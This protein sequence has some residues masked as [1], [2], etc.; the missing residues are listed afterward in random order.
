MAV[1]TEAKPE[2]KNYSKKIST[3]TIGLQTR[4]LE[5]IAQKAKGKAVAVARVYGI[6]RGMAQGETDIGPYWKFDG[7]FEAV[8]L[9][10]RTTHRARALV[11]P[12]VAESFVQ[13]SLSSAK[14]ENPEATVTIGMDIT[15]SEHKSSKGGT[16]F[17][18]GVSPLTE[19][20]SDPLTALGKQF[21]ELPKLLN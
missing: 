18:Y 8:N 10:S 13:E 5:E 15:V 4:E 3:A 21:G 16:K 17:K 12:Q 9:V 11:L 19:A 1:K 6:A 14:I 2:P 20:G 7:E